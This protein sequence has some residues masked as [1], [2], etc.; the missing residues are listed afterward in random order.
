MFDLPQ[1]G[2]VGMM[3]PASKIYNMIK[4][5]KEVTA[6]HNGDASGA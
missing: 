3:S 2:N 5:Y 4:D 1:R 6:T